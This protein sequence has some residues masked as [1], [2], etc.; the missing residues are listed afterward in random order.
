V[1]GKKIILINF[2]PGIGSSYT[3]KGAIYPSTATLLLGTLLSKDG[4]DVQ[5]IDGAYHEDYLETLENS[6]KDSEVLY[7]G[8]TVMT[9]QIP[10]ALEASR[11]IKTNS[12]NVLTVWGGPHPT[13]F[14]ERTLKNEYVDVVAIN[15]GAFTALDLARCLENGGELSNVKGI[16]YKDKKKKM[17][18]TE[19]REL[20]DIRK[21]PNLDFNL[22]DVDR[23]LNPEK[24][25]VFQREFPGYNGRIKIMPILTGLGCPYKCQFCINV[26]LKRRYRYRS[27]AEIVQE[28]KSLKGNYQVNNE[29]FFVN[30]K[31]ANEF[32]SLV[33]KEGLHFNWRMWCR[34]DHFGEDYINDKL[35]ERLSNIGHGSMV[36]G[37]ESANQVTLDLLKK[38]IT[39]QQTIESL[40][41]ITGTNILPRYSF[42]VGLENESLEEIRH[43]YR[44]CLKMKEINPIVDIAGPYIFRLYPGSPIYD[45]LIGRYGLNMPNDLESWADYLKNKDT[46]TEMPWVPV[47]F[48]KITKLVDFYSLYA[49]SSFPQ[50]IPI[51]HKIIFS[52]W[53]KLGRIRLKYFFFR[54][55]FEYWIHFVLRNIYK[56]FSQFL[57]LRPFF[58]ERKST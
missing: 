16:G 3:N 8:M 5:I 58:R 13:L 37:G 26:I 25:T 36:M 9:T 15:E 38:E 44:F 49:L 55:P 47:T 12:E 6:V 24:D 27:A 45:R 4:Y 21:L 22:I 48:Q 46:Y 39:P 50:K 32:L 31:R 2:L 14:P 53:R 17:I 29:D 42:M 52:L 57:N 33:E 28:I 10:F 1:N 54:L 34:V 11:V 41:L 40:K 18:C 35:I 19:P 43:T 7:A 23:Y 56:T 51:H 20:E 30:K